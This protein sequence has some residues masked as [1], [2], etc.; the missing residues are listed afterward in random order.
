VI[1]YRITSPIF[2][3]IRQRLSGGLS[4]RPR[5]WVYQEQAVL[6]LVSVSYLD[7]TLGPAD[8]PA[9]LTLFLSPHLCTLSTHSALARAKRT[10]FPFPALA[11]SLIVLS[12]SLPAAL[13][14]YYLMSPPT[15]MDEG[16]IAAPRKSGVLA[17]FPD[18]DLSIN[19]ARLFMAAMVLGSCNMWIL[20]GRDTI[21]RSIGVDRGEMIKAGR[22]VGLGYW[23]IIVALVCFGGWVSEKLEVLGVIATIAISWLLPCKSFINIRP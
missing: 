9:T 5:S 10:S 7:L 16:V 18:Q 19:V 20:R 1:D 3:T 21:L 14:P 23:A 4:Q 17:R 11:A 8:D 13:V 12:L 15:G 2:L 6:E 22:W